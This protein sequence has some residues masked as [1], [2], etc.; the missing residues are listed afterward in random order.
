MKLGNYFR[1]TIFLRFYYDID[2][3]FKYA[4]GP[5]VWILK[6]IQK[7]LNCSIDLS[8]C[9]NSSC[10][11]VLAHRTLYNV[12]HSTTLEGYAY[13]FKLF[14]FNIKFVALNIQCM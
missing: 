11:D 10:E 3:D 2:K 7:S 8:I 1:Q 6:D 4:D 5:L 13:A 12:I 9:L 14:E